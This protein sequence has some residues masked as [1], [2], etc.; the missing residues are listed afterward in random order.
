MLALAS[1][2]QKSVFVCVYVA[3]DTI[4]ARLL[5]YFLI[6]VAAIY[7]RCQHGSSFLSRGQT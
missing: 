1:Q 7:L 6:G 4:K 3:S 5:G 2:P